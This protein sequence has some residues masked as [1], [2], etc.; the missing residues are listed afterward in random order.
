[1][2]NR[3]FDQKFLA[4]K[5]RYFVQS[6]MASFSI[7][8]ILLIL[9]AFEQTAL[10]ASL[11]ASSFIVFAMPSAYSAKPRSIVGGY[12]WG[13]LMGI[14]FNKLARTTL[15]ESL[16]MSHVWQYTVFTAV[17]VG[18]TIFLMV[19]TNTE[20]P[21]AAGMALGLVLQDWVFRTLFFVILAIV[22]LAAIRAVFGKYL[23]DLH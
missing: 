3:F 20:H 23:I 14:V 17:A 4:N 19:I 6:A 21:P 11:G 10:I 5:T 16:H 13:I 8:V 22:I 7:L 1:M 9:N 2:P 18:L 15:V 12:T